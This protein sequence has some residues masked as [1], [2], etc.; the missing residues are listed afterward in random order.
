MYLPSEFYPACTVPEMV[1]EDRFQ[2]RANQLQGLLLG[3]QSQAEAKGVDDATQKRTA[4]AS[5]GY[6]K[7]CYSVLSKEGTAA[8]SNGYVIL[9]YSV[10]SKEGTAVAS[11]GYVK[12]CYS[13]LAKEGTAAAFNGY[14]ILCYSVLSKK[15]P[16]AASDGLCYTLLF[17]LI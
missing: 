10:L 14:V 15:G 16:A 1:Q 11:N 8:A 12:L 17:C 7:L 9:C 2:H 4:V 6:V 3:H 5:N 13:V